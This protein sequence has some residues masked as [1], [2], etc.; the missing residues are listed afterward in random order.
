MNFHIGIFRTIFYYNNSL[1]LLCFLKTFFK[2]SFPLFDFTGQI[3][4]RLLLSFFNIRKKN[5]SLTLLIIFNTLNK[6][7]RK[8]FRQEWICIHFL[9]KYLV[10]ETVFSTA[11]YFKSRIVSIFLFASCKNM[12]LDEWIRLYRSHSVL[13]RATNTPIRLKWSE[14]ST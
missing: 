5:P 8:A 3:I 10:L 14:R 4:M 7:I 2:S 11:I 9:Q 12:K 13:E 1:H 6:R